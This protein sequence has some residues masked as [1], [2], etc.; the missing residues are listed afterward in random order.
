MTLQDQFSHYYYYGNLSRE[1]IAKLLNMSNNNTSYRDY[2][3]DLN[4]AEQ[5]HHT[6]TCFSR[7]TCP[8]TSGSLTSSCRLRAQSAS[9]A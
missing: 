3:Y 7:I 9:L 1:D 4:Y 8:T 6:P 5:T 2:Y